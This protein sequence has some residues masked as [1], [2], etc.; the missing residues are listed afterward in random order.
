ML[1]TEYV[2]NCNCNYERIHLEQKP[3]DNRYQYCILNRGGI[4]YLLP[5]GLRY[6]NGEAYLYYDISSTQNVWQL[7]AERSIGR[8]WFKDFLWGVKQM[9]RELDR[10]LLEE[11]SIIW[12]PQQVFQDL[13]KNDFFFLYIPYYKGENGLSE[14]MDYLVEHVDYSDEFFVEFVYA[15][16]EQIKTVGLEYLRKQIHE[17]WLAMERKQKAEKEVTIVQNAEANETTSQ[18]S[19]NEEEIVS[20]RNVR[21]FWEGRRKKAREKEDYREKMRQRLLGAEQYAVCETSV[22][23]GNDREDVREEFQEE[24]AFPEEEYGKTIYIEET[25]TRAEPGLY[26]SDGELVVKLEQFPFVIGKKKDVV[27]GVIDEPSISRMHAR[28]EEEDGKIYI[29]DLNS[30]NGTCKNGIMLSPN[31]K[32]EVFA[33]D[34]IW[35]GR[36]QFIYR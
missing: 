21:F 12:S 20:K 35:F 17:D 22:Y 5:G 16:Y 14:F 7:F 6:I 10:F 29:T 9:Q 31:R 19:K 4:R 28:F 8:D 3:E 13:E 24:C 2:R 18:T 36:L 32:I 27:D 25:V 26:R 33:E 1:E 23:E 34:E 30:T 11:Q 15:A